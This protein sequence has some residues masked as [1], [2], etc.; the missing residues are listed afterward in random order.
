MI[1]WR[2]NMNKK[3]VLIVTRNVSQERGV[4]IVKFTKALVDKLTASGYGSLAVMTMM[5]GTYVTLDSL[6]DT[7]DRGRSSARPKE[8]ISFED[9]RVRN[10]YEA[11]VVVGGDGTMVGVCRD[12]AD[13]RPVLIGVN[14]GHLGFITDLSLT[15]RVD[16]IIE[17]LEGSPGIH[18]LDERRMLLS[19]SNNKGRRLALNEVAI[20]AINGRVLGFSVFLDEEFAYK[21]RGD[22][23]LITTPTGS[24]YNASAG[25]PLIHPSA[26][27]IGITPLLP[28]SLAQR[29][30]VV[31]DGQAVKIEVTQG[32]PGLFIDGNRVSE[33]EDPQLFTVQ[34]V[35]HMQ[36]VTFRHPDDYSF[37]RTLR[38]KLNW[39][40]EPGSR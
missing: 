15:T 9:I 17:M 1:T 20:K 11:I 10:S 27:V 34:A 4:E 21:C 35:S 32:E 31:P 23:I 28:Q 25:G 19:C 18:Y 14:A 29:S 8:V 12:L 22:G 16:R 40:L 39:Q 13:P 2:G 36:S 33:L 3:Q 26:R 24:T 7:L 30:L 38:E 37:L 5:D 6:M